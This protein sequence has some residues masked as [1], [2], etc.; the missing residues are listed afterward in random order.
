VTAGAIPLPA[1]WRADAD[2]LRRRGAV[3][4]AEALES[5]AVELEAFEQERQLEAFEQERQLEALTL[6]QAVIESGYSYSALEKMVRAGQLQNVGIR[7]KPRVRRGD[8]PRKVIA[9]KPMTATGPDLAG[10]ALRGRVSSPNGS[11]PL[12]QPRRASHGM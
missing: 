9:P 8:L 6:E 3:P 12:A 4:Q 10:D 11:R 2:I 5:C 1:R 7:G